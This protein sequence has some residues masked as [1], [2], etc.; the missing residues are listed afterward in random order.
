MGN[1]N[2][3]QALTALVEQLHDKVDQL[4]ADV[5]RLGAVAASPAAAASDGAADSADE[6]VPEPEEVPVAEA[7]PNPAVAVVFDFVAAA[8]STNDTECWSELERLTHSSALMAPRSLDHLKAFSWKKLRANAGRYFA[9]REEIRA[10]RVV[11]ASIDETT[12]NVKVFI[13]HGNG[14]ASPLVV[15]R[16]AEAGGEWRVQ[17]CSL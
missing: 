5:Q 15:A 17:T 1:E 9:S 14:S 2:E 16:D 6:K 8:L 4:A 10:E 7:P 11:P 12:Q 13:A 3:L